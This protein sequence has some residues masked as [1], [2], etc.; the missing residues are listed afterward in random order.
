MLFPEPEPES[1]SQEE[2]DRFYRIRN[3]AY[4]DRE[5]AARLIKE[6]PTILDA[7]NGIGETALHFLAVENEMD[8]VAWLYDQGAEIDTRNDFEATP[9]IE[10]AGSGHLD[11]CRW[12]LDRG[13]DP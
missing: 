1:R 10:A 11:L 9:L 2:L 5:K 7:R 12:L 6:D 4:E 13:A 3:A 8:S